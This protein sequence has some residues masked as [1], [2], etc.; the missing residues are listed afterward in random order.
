MDDERL[1]P[2]YFMIVSEEESTGLVLVN[3]GRYNTVDEYANHVLG[4]SKVGRRIHYRSGLGLEF[5]DQ[6]EL[7]RLFTPFHDK[8]MKKVSRD[9]AAA[10]VKA[11]N[12][13]GDTPRC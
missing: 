2:I 4:L 3:T 6:M 12:V 8:P 11:E 9:L 7:L 13:T 10:I 5:D 1:D